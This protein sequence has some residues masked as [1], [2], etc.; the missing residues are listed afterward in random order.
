MNR[1]ISA[2]GGARFTGRMTVLLAATL[3]ALASLLA[4]FV[5]AKSSG[6]Q[7]Q[8]ITV[9]P[10]EVGF[11]AVEVSASPETRAISIKNTGD[12][13]LVIGGVDISGTDA[14]DFSLAT[15]IDPL[16]GLS[17][18]AGDAVTLDVNFDPATAGAKEATLTLKNLLGQAIPGAPQINVS[19]TGVTVAPTAPGCDI[20]GTD[21]GE[22]LTGTPDDEVIC[23]LGGNDQVNGL[24]GSDTLRGGRG[25]DRLVDTTASRSPTNPS[26][27]EADKL[28]GET[29][30][31]RINSKDGDG[32]D[33]VNGG[34]QR[35]RIRKDKGD[36]GKRR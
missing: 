19:G 2:T 35:D 25:K 20:V 24:G 14:G 34:P 32:A 22:T 15:T 4:A 30:R 16:N 28:F 5:L 18:G 23:A 13:T 9:N 29:G 8:T 21:N 33:M 7:T 36:Q 17:V 11:G 10:S 3:L 26:A 6:A 27:P 31:D 12:T 1:S